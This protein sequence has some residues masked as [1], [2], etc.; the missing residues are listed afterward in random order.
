[1]IKCDK[2]NTNQEPKSTNNKTEKYNCNL[3]FNKGIKP[4]D[5]IFK[6]SVIA[7]NKEKNKALE[8]QK[9]PVIKVLPIPPTSPPPP[10]PNPQ[11][12][13]FSTSATS[14][15]EIASNTQNSKTQSKSNDVKTLP[16]PI[17]LSWNIANH[18]KIKQIKKFKKKRISHN[19]SCK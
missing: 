12:I 13:N 14:Y 18:Q 8:V 3:T 17:R 4:D 16:P 2:K 6:L 9:T 7:K 10:V 5:Y 19:L 15:Q 1:M 11:I